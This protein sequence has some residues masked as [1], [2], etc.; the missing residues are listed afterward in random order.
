M[1]VTINSTNPR[2]TIQQYGDATREES[3]PTV[4]PQTLTKWKRFVLADTQD[5]AREKHT[6]YGSRIIMLCEE[7]CFSKATSFS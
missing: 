3:K 4:G 5:A 7:Q 6:M 2:R 1:F